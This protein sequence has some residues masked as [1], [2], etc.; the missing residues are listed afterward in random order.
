MIPP[1]VING[2][3]SGAKITLT[4]DNQGRVDTATVTSR[5]KNYR[6]LLANVRN[7]SVLVTND[8]TID[9]FWSIYAWDDIRKVFFRSRSQAYDTTKYWNKIDWYDTGYS[10][11][12]QIT[13]EIL[14]VFQEPEYF[15]SVGDLIR[16]KEYGTGGW[17]VF[18]K[19]TNTGSAFSDRFKLVARENGTIELKSS[20]YVSLPLKSEVSKSFGICLYPSSSVNEEYGISNLLW[21]G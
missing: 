17:A 15:I 21:Q 20:L 16:V 7:F 19:I 8:S 12:T 1:V 18:E 6:T 3:G 5:G 13:R 14:S 9:N 4:L 11:N 2:D 10:A